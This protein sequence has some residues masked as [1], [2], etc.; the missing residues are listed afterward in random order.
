[1]QAKLNIFLFFAFIIV[2]GFNYSLN[3]AQEIVNEQ[4]NYR[5]V[6]EPD[7]SQFDTLIV[8]E[9]TKSLESVDTLLYSYTKAL[10]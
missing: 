1:M 5:Q 10:K 9:V 6:L 8:K 3:N 2:L 4:H 7:N